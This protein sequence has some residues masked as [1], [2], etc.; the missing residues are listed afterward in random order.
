MRTLSVNALNKLRTRLGT[1]PIII[2]EIQWIQGGGW[3]M[4]ASKNIG[5]SVLG[6][7][8]T[9]GNMD[10][11]IGI[12]ENDASQEVSVVL[13]DTDGSLKQIIDNHDIHKRD[14]RVW[15]WFD[16]LDLTDKFLLFCGKINSPI[17]WNEGERT[18]SFD[19]I[20]QLEDTEFGFS[21]EEGEFDFIPA[22]LIGKAWP[23]IFGTPLDVP[24]VRIGEA[25]HGTSLAGIGITTGEGQVGDGG[26]SAAIAQHSGGQA[27]TNIQAGHLSYIASAWMGVDSDLAEQFREQA[28]NIRSQ[29]AN[30]LGS[31]YANLQKNLEAAQQQVADSKTGSE[32]AN[33]VRILGGEYFPRGLITLQIGGGTFTG[34]FGGTDTTD[35]L[36]TIYSKYHAEDQA[37][38]DAEIA[39]STTTSSFTPSGGAFD[40][41]NKIP[42]RPN[43]YYRTHGSLYT[44]PVETTSIG[45]VGAK[46]S[47]IDAGSDVTLVG[48]EEITYI[49]SIVPGTVLSVKGF[50]TFNGI[51]HFVHIPNNLYTVRNRTYGVINTVEIV[52]SKTLSTIE[53]QNWDDDVYVT[54]QSSIGPNIVDILEYII[55]LYTDFNI[56][57]TSFAEVEAILANF[58]ANFAVLDRKNVLTILQEIAFQACCNLRLINGT[59]YLTHLPTKPTSLDTI[60]ENDVEVNSM[61]ISSSPTEDLVTKIIA[62]WRETYAKDVNK[63]ILR[64]NITKYGVQE[65]TFDFYIYNTSD[66]VQKAATFWLIRKANTWK[67][68]KFKTFMNKLNLESFDCVTLQFKTPYLSTVGTDVL[69][70]TSVVDTGNYTIELDCWTPVRF[71]EMTPYDFSWPAS[72]SIHQIF[73]T[74]EDIAWGYDGGGGI[75]VD[76]EGILPAAPRNGGTSCEDSAQAGNSSRSSQDKA[77]KKSGINSGK[78]D[79]GNNNV[80]DW[81]YDADSASAASRAQ[82]YQTAKALTT[83]VDT[84]KPPGPIQRTSAPP[85]PPV[86]L[87][88]ST[89]QVTGDGLVLDLTKT[90]VMD[91]ANS[92]DVA[93]LADFLQFKDSKLYI[94]TTAEFID[95]TEQIAEFDF[96]Y[97]DETSKFGAGTAFLQ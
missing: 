77:K 2:L 14:V 60:T 89:T 26:A 69:I 71:G 37:A 35:D 33:P 85:L 44:T 66:L 31:V 86:E 70:S 12:S 54:F 79:R 88:A 67:H 23:S 74:V 8:L 30:S 53:G 92:A 63:M 16:G 22:N 17:E 18:L 84:T 64:Y 29:Q 72:V 5:T 36:F 55:D 11:A 42:C 87:G 97:D 62:E 21:P 7:I 49:V 73:P 82:A 94:K 9:I 6:K 95:D 76:A 25:I 46:Y 48:T 65:S 45:A 50:K 68:I 80:S 96:R 28:N 61:V 10:D 93:Y 3:S 24:V 19:I 75:G 32:G 56:D 40:Y 27:S 47:W 20:S 59:F 39:A 4:Y 1:E 58:P 38:Y 41:I 78:S 15:Q 81:G 51:K 83:T 57:A 52:F 43:C 13:D 34:A 91:G 90:K